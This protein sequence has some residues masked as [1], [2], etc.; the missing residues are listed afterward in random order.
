MRDWDSSLM[1]ACHFPGFEK[2]V[3]S[4]LARGPDAGA[5]IY[6]FVPVQY[7]SCQRA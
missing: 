4:L 1:L 6:V 3:S 7:H 5:I 2:H